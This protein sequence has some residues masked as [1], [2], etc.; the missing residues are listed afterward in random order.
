MRAMISQA[1]SDRDPADPHAHNLYRLVSVWNVTRRHP[2]TIDIPP[3]PRVPNHPA[4]ELVEHNVHRRAVAAGDVAELQSID[5]EVGVHARSI[6]LPIA[7][8]EIGALLRLRKRRIVQ[9]G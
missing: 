8:D 2:E 9:M 3:A 6:A 1:G 4:I 7:P 5:S